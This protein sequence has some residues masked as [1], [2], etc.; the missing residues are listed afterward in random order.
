MANMKK[1]P[2]WQWLPIFRWRIVEFVEAADEIPECLP[3][4]AAILV[5]SRQRPKWLAF[6]CPCRA[7][8]RIMVTLDPR[9]DP[10]WTLFDEHRLTVGPSFDYRAPDRSCHFFIHRGRVKWAR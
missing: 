2:W 7:G 1:L 9:H 4:N 6:D 10:H 5:G 8:H 3:R